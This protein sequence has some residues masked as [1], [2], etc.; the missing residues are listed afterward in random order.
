MRDSLLAVLAII[1]LLLAGCSPF[2]RETTITDTQ[3]LPCPGVEIETRCGGSIWTLDRI[4][5]MTPA[6]VIRDWALGKRERECLA[7]AVSTWEEAHAECYA[8][9]NG[10]FQ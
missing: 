4:E 3:R 5:E 9:D 2:A 1:A 7:R 8:R 10:F 6:Q